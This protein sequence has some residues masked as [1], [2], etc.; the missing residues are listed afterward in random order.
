MSEIAK[1]EYI[2]P[3][4]DKRPFLVRLWRGQIPLGI[5][6]WLYGVVGALIIRFISPIITYIMAAN[7]SR[8]SELHISIVRYVWL[9]FVLAFSVVIYVGI[10]RSANRYALEKPKRV[11]YARLA[12]LMTVIGST[13]TAAA[14][15]QTSNV[16]NPISPYERMQLSAAIAGLNAHLPRKIDDVTNLRKIDIKNSN[17]IY[18]LSLTSVIQ[19]KDAFATN[20]KARIKA[21]C[22]SPGIV[23]V[24]KYSSRVDYVYSDPSASNF[25]TIELQQSDC[26]P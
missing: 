14:L 21:S 5:T 22:K 1:T 18:Y 11:T 2:I 8:L 3:P 4:I 19:D 26:A 9:A 10:W 7:A 16:F 12:Q 15:F 17:V 25:A 6:Y 13:T 24:L 20:M 23:S